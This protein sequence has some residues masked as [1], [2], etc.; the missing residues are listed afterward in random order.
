MP[1]TSGYASHLGIL[2]EVCD[3]LKPRDAIEFGCGY[4]S[5]PYLLD[6][7]EELLSIE[8]NREWLYKVEERLTESQR[9]RWVRM[10]ITNELLVWLMPGVMHET[11]LVLVDGADYRARKDVA[12]ACMLFQT[13]RVVVCHDSERMEYNY[14]QVMLPEGWQCIRIEEE[15]PWTSVY[16]TDG[17]LASALSGHRQTVCR[18]TWEMRNIRYPS[19]KSYEEQQRDKAIT[20]AGGTVLAGE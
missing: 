18:S 10:P 2:G 12:Q 6:R 8:L 19:I 15:M 7:C 20:A 3:V 17:G 5:T 4:H 11:G 14:D 9:K 13:A 1:E 16:T